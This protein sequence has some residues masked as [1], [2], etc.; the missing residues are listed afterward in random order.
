[1]K[2]TNISKGPRGIN[3]KA[4]PVLIEP[5]ETRDDLEVVEAELEVAKATGWFD[6]SGKAA[7]ED[8]K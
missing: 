8:K 2:V 6:I 4:G 7:A 5:G 3:T 1:M